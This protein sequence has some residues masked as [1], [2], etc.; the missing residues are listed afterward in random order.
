MV[1][2]RMVS[3][4]SS[5]SG[6]RKF[7]EMFLIGPQEKTTLTTKPILEAFDAVLQWMW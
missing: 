4:K 5:N 1:A 6:I 7:V 3:V 2:D